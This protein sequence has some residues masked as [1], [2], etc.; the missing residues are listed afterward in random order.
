MLQ[1]AANKAPE[2]SPR[3]QEALEMVKYLDATIQ[4]EAANKAQDN[5]T[6]K[7]RTGRRKP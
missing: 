1:Q 7:G 3:K 2:G 4:G 5:K 6:D